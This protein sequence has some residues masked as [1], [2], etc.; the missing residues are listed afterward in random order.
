ME[1]SDE[2]DEEVKEEG[3]DT[4]NNKEEDLKV[5]K[6]KHKVKSVDWFHA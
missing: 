2:E 4:N 3:K 6:I 1:L 5:N